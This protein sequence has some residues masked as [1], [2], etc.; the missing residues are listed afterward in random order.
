MTAAGDRDLVLGVLRRV[1]GRVSLEEISYKT[2]LTRSRLLSA[3]VELEE[4]GLA[5]PM[6]WEAVRHQEAA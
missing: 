1:G 6:S 4:Q 2:K 3:L 5:A